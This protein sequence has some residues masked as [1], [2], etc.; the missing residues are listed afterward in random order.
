MTTYTF[1]RVRI[2]T[3]TAVY[4][5]VERNL[6][7]DTAA[8]EWMGCEVIGA[9]QELRGFRSGESAPFARREFGHLV[10]VLS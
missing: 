4:D 3:P 7:D 9:G 1:R 10:E 2:D 5:T 8:V 6:P